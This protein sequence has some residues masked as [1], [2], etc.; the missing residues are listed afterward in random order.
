MGWIVW[1]IVI[2]VI[3]SGVVIFTKSRA[4]SWTPDGGPASTTPS[5]NAARN[6]VEASPVDPRPFGSVTDELTKLMALR[7]GGALSEAEFAAQKARVLS[8]SATTSTLF[9]GTVDV[10]LVR[11]GRRKINVIK[12]VRELFQLRL[13]DAK[14]L[15]ESAPATMCT[16]VPEVEARRIVAM[17][18]A[19]GA[20][21]ELR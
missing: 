13:K 12:V 16:G 17:L 5:D 8:G 10:V 9:S 1:I 20:T 15:V 3:A 11:V 6:P 19:E 14:D 7:D 2:G 18:E 21:C 4:A